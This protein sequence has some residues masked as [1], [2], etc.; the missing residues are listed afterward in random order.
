MQAEINPDRIKDETMKPSFS[1]IP[2]FALILSLLGCGD[3]DTK[4]SGVDV[5]GPTTIS[6]ADTANR[7]L[8]PHIVY[9][10]SDDLGADLGPCLNDLN[11]MPNMEKRC[12]S[13]LVFE[14][15]YANPY[16]TPTRAGI[17]L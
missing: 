15:A 10:T 3:Q 12:S 5:A 2:C 16:C 9:I 4:S 13:S 14:R 6:S 7:S 8:R 11:L 1:A 17:L